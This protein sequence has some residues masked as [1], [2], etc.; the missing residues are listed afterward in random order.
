MDNRDLYNNIGKLAEAS[1]RQLAT[2]FKS[3]TGIDAPAG[4]FDQSSFEAYLRYVKHVS[5]EQSSALRKPAHKWGKL[6]QG[7]K[8]LFE[9]I[10]KRAEATYEQMFDTR[11][12]LSQRLFVFYPRAVLVAGDI[13][14][15]LE[16]GKTF[17][18]RMQEEMF[19]ANVKHRI[20][21]PE[22]YESGHVFSTEKEYFAA[23]RDPTMKDI[24]LKYASSDSTYLMFRCNMSLSPLRRKVVKPKKGVG[25]WFEKWAIER[26]I[27]ALIVPSISQEDLERL[28]RKEKID[29]G[30]ESPNPT[31]P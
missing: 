14:R 11:T 25:G 16:R 7:E 21:H 9:Q 2:R 27:A 8:E 6:T 19:R 30:L 22:K 15:D 31:H 17:L 24:M 23:L 20:K 1:V 10:A 4:M 13:G 3:Y 5:S 26:N 29:L 18:R 28:I 12:T